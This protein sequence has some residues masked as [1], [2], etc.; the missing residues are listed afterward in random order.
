MWQEKETKTANYPDNNEKNIDDKYVCTYSDNE[1]KVAIFGSISGVSGV[2]VYC[3]SAS[4]VENMKDLLLPSVSSWWHL[5]I[6]CVSNSFVE[7]LIL[8]S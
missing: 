4:I 6:N 7:W 3:S 2:S 1:I 8:I 5:S